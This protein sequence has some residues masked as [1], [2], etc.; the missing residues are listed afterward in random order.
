M[1]DPI[2]NT[3]PPPTPS[4][5][6]L[7]RVIIGLIAL[8]V[9]AVVGIIVLAYVDKTAPDA[10]DVALGAVVGALGSVLVGRRP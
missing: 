6:L 7:S 9:L 3:E 10:L 8:G 2:G 4:D 1:T 5:V